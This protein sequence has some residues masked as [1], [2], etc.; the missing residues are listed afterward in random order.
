[1]KKTCETSCFSTL[2]HIV[3]YVYNNGRV[4]KWIVNQYLKNGWTEAAGTVE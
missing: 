3:S 1:M 4:I 2:N